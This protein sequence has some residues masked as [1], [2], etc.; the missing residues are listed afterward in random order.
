[1]TTM[2]DEALKT[3]APNEKLIVI[4]LGKHRKGRI[5][6]LREGR[7]PL[8]EEVQEALEELRASGVLPANAQPVVFV[9][10]EKSE[11]MTLMRGLLR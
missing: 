5:K 1:M 3:N 8:L 2:S 4:D 9:V 7:G 11:E 10:K 6:K